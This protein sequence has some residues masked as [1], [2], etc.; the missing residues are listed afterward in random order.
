P[1]SSGA[2]QELHMRK[3]FVAGKPAQT[4][5]ACHHRPWHGLPARAAA[6]PTLGSEPAAAW[7][8][9]PCHGKA[10]KVGNS[11][12]GVDA[13]A[14]S[15]D[16]LEHARLNDSKSAQRVVHL[17]TPPASTSTANP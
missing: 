3:S 12:R 4:R 9:W 14:K 15:P 13:T 1:S 7:P 6:L 8:R 16:A 11:L 5:R 10:A 17:Q 2:R